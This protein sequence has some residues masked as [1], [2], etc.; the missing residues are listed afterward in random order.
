M[1]R[2][3]ALPLSYVKEHYHGDVYIFVFNVLNLYTNERLP[4]SYLDTLE[5]KLEKAIKGDQV[6]FAIV[7]IKLAERLYDLAHAS[8]YIYLREIEYMAHETLTTD[9]PLAN[10]YLGPELAAILKKQLKKH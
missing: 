5:N 4:H 9:V 1:V 10:Q 2:Y 3:T 6:Q 7:V 8:S